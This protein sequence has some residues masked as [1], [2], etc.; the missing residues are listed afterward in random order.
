M[1]IRA[2]L[3]DDDDMAE[4]IQT[5]K[6]KKTTFRRR[7]S[8]IPKSIHG[9]TKGLVE[10]ATGWFQVLVI[11]NFL[12]YSSTNGT[13]AFHWFSRADPIWQQI[14]Q[15][16][17]TANVAASDFARGI[18]PALLEIGDNVRP[19]LRGRL[20][21]GQLLGECRSH[22]WF[23]QRLQDDYKSTELF[24]TRANGRQIEGADGNGHGQTIQSSNKGTRSEP[25]PC[26]RYS[27][28][29]VLP[30]VSP[31]HHVGCHRHN[32]R[33]GARFGG[34]QFGRQ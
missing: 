31:A 7:G 32:R 13:H 8:P 17:H 24:A 29:C 19:L 14:R 1:G 10:S 33:K 25:I 27:A 6:M 4:V 18:H 3:E 16:F 20:Q 34:A 15:R 21:N 26:R 23:A 30:T 22:H 11:T 2:R 12:F 28:R 5:S 9:R